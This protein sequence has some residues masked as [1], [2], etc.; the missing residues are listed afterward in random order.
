MTEAMSEA[1][2]RWLGDRWRLRVN[3]IW[4]VGGDT[5]K[6][7]PE[8]VQAYR[9]LA[10]GLRAGGAK[11]PITFH[12]SGGRIPSRGIS[13]AELLPAEGWWLDFDSVQVHGYA[14]QA[15]PRV[16]VYAAP[17]SAGLRARQAPAPPT[18]LCVGGTQV[19]SR[20]LAS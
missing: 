18:V 19:T 20:S 2:G 11:Q 4:A 9:G 16:S 7:A 15:A 5:R 1:F 14:R 13:S 10:R 12:P 17:V 3:L 8:D 6:D